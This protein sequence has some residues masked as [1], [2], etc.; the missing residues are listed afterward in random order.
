MSCLIIILAYYFVT[1]VQ[2]V[3]L[4]LFCINIPLLYFDF[5]YHNF[6]GLT[7][8]MTRSEHLAP[9]RQERKNHNTAELVLGL[10]SNSRSAHVGGLNKN[11]LTT[12]QNRLL[13]SFALD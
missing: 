8:K 4:T 9:K 11:W 7:N 10:K 6:I 1:F 13:E 5:K 2:K 3:E 12:F